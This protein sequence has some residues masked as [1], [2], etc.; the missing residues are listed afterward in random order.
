MPILPV[1]L[2]LLAT[3]LLGQALVRLVLSPP[4]QRQSCLKRGG[5]GS[6]LFL[7]L[8][9]G[10]LSL[11]SSVAAG[12]SQASLVLLFTA[13]LKAWLIVTL[14]SRQELERFAKFVLIVAA[15]V[16][17]FA[18][19]QVIGDL[20]GLPANLTYLLPHYSSQSTFILPRPQSVSLEPLYFAHYLFLPLG[21]LVYDIL[22]KRRGIWRFGLL[23]ASLGM[24]ILTASRGALLGLVMIGLIGGYSIIFTRIKRRKLL[25]ALT[26]LAVSVLVA[27]VITLF[28]YYQKSPVREVV[29]VPRTAGA[30]IRHLVD[31]NDRSANTRYELWPRAIELIEQRPVTGVGFFASRVA[32][33]PGLSP[34]A[35]TTAQP[36]NNDYLS[37]LAEVGWLGLVV[38]LPLIVML[39]WRFSQVVASGL[40]HQATPYVLA[41]VGMAVQACTFQSILLLRTWVVVGLIIAW[42]I[43]RREHA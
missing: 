29:G 17:A 22:R 15:A 38:T 30:L 16:V 39:L 18:Y 9:A 4:S 42:C 11:P 8:L 12:F 14:A 37:Y 32:L 31:F 28:G 3:L 13:L 1:S 36:L 25:L 43:P 20:A 34:A 26:L 40:R 6:I 23:A 27:G 35:A 24:I 21:I 7:P 5:Y 19:F 41:L 33:H 2:H 10:L